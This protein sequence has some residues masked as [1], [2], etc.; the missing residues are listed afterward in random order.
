MSRSGGVVGEKT[1][2]SCDPGSTFTLLVIF[3]SMHVK[4]EYK[5]CWFVLDGRWGFTDY[6][7]VVSS[8]GQRSGFRASE[9]V[10]GLATVE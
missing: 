10:N 9:R 2:V 3:Y 8:S 6:S 4:G 5:W 7:T 1:G